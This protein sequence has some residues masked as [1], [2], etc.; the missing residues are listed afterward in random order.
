MP[1]RPS[2]SPTTVSAANPR[3]RPPFTTLV[4][5]LTAIIF[6]L[7][8]SSR[9]SEGMPL[10]WIL[11]I[12]RLSELQ[13]G[14][15]RGLGQRLHAAVESV[16]RTVESNALDSRGLGLLRQARTDQFGGIRVAT[17]ALGRRE[18][19]AHFGL[20]RRGRDQHLA[21]V[22]RHHTRVNVLVGAVDRQAIDPLQ[23]DAGTGRARAAQAGLFLLD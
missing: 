4:T 15:T 14:F 8:P 2:P 22:G 21:A 23:R 7:S 12:A 9:S 1:M 13:A 5:R 17:L 18:L 3:M 10:G 20:D 16:T 11:A 19:L 6:S